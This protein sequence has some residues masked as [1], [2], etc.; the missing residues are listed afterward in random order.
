MSKH[1]GPPGNPVK[2]KDFAVYPV[3]A[4]KLCKTAMKGS[5]RIHQSGGKSA[6]S[7]IL[8]HLTLVHQ[9]KHSADGKR[10]LADFVG[11]GRVRRH[12]QI[13]LQIFGRS[14][15]LAEAVAQQSALLYIF[16]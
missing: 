9:G 4:E 11:I 1:S 14:R 8:V 12:L 5:G 10:S 13:L 16:G 7:L 15:D 3:G 6:L 2:M